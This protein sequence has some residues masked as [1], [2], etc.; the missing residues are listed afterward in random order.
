[1]AALA[2]IALAA[3]CSRL[4]W[5]TDRDNHGAQAFYQRLGVPPRE[6]KVFYRAEGQALRAIAASGDRT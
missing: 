6:S 4:E 3:G 5:T 2:E 1:M